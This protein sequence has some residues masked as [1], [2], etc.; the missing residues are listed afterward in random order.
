M[1]ENILE[2]VEKFLN[3]SDQKLEE[4]SEINQTL[5]LEENE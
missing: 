5:Q 4:L 2:T 3:Y 1:T